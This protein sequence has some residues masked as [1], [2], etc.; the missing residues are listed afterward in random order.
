MDNIVSLH[1]DLTSH[2][3]RHG[4][5]ESFFV[6]DP[7]RRHIHKASVRDRLLHHAIYCISYPFFDQTFIGDSYSCR[8]DKGVHKA[9]NKFRSMSYKVSK[10]GHRACW[11]LKCDIRKFF[12]SINHNTLVNI[13]KQYIPDKDVMWLLEEVIGSFSV[14][15][16]HPC[17]PL[18]IK[19]R[20]S[21]GLPLGNLTS[22][23]FA[24]IYLNTF[25]QFV[26]HKLKAKYYI[27]Y[28]DDFVFLSHDKQWLEGQIPKIRDFLQNELL[29]VLHPNKI[30]LQTMSSGIDFLG[31]KHFTDHR[32]VRKTTQKRMM[33]RLVVNPTNETLQSYLGLLKHG[34]GLKMR[35]ELLNEFWFFSR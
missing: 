27:R 22:Q 21:V 28:A 8:K 5:Y 18:L 1:Q 20:G 25:D 33:K 4:G 6:N 16:P 11:I 15:L 32:V 2:T 9:L 23:L 3:Y 35:D 34:D 12:D 31:W 30:V 10:N 19:E 13:L 24:N 7:K 14:R 29:L 17:T 26:K